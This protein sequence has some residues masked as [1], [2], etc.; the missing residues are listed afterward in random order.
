MLL[1]SYLFG[2]FTLLGKLTPMKVAQYKKYFRNE[3]SNY[4]ISIEL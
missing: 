3:I 2:T 1:N 4:P